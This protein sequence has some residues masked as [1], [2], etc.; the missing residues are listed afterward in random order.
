MQEKNMTAMVSCFAKAY[1]YKNN[2]CKIFS[3]PIAEKILS[4]EE[5][6][7]IANNMTEGIKFFNPNF[8]GTKEQA[9]RWIVDNQLS[10][11]VLGRS[12]FCEKL[13]QNDIKLGCKQFLMYASGYD[14]WIYKYSIKNLKVFE[15]DKD[16][17]IDDKT[18]RLSNCNIDLSNV[19]F[20]KSDFTHKDWIKSILSSNY[21]ANEKS[22]NSL[23]GISYYL[24]K[25]EFFNMI[26]SISNIIS[27][28]SSVIFD[29]PTYV[30]SKETMIN[31]KL[32]NG[33]KEKMQSKYSYEE[34]E[35]ILS[36]NN[37]LIYEHL[38]DCQMTN[39]YFEIYNFF[40]PHNK[41]IAP[42]GVAYCL[43]IKKVD[44]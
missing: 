30:E 43:A 2:K 29:Y 27:E 4:E 18:K 8:E 24:K 19:S 6:N 15:I 7:S 21:N 5:Y 42:K 37:L 40:N 11:S 41:I 39:N 23:L 17:M 35:K 3:D 26:K 44:K 20:I 16:E 12:A 28:G 38:D 31:E 14:T 9:L 22:F 33:A 32:A 13:F 1:H 10:P 34:I 25:D 36:D